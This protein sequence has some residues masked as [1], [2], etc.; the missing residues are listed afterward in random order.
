M[1]VGFFLTLSSKSV[2]RGM[3]LTVEYEKTIDTLEDMLDSKMPALLPVDTSMKFKLVTDPREEV[4]ELAKR[5]VQYK[6][7]NSMPDWVDKG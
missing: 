5:V 7:G 3:M 4:Q 2:L 6:M 1:L